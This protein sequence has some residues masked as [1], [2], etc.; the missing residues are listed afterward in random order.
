M[1]L[2]GSD[3][4]FIVSFK[5]LWAC[6]HA[7]RQNWWVTGT[8][9]MLASLHALVA[10]FKKKIQGFVEQDEKSHLVSGLWVGPVNY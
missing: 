8:R 3:D 7:Q 6:K 9:R 10:L 2:T 4:V 1:K 5:E